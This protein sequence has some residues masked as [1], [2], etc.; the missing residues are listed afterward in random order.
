MYGTVEILPNSLLY[1]YD[2]IDFETH[3]MRSNVQNL[4]FSSIYVGKYG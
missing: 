3:T 2:G 1:D 4:K